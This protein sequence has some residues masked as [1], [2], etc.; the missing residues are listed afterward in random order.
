MASE[1]ADSKKFLPFTRLIFYYHK[2][3]LQS[4]GMSGTVRESRRELHEKSLAKLSTYHE[5]DHV[6]NSSAQVM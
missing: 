4:S 5:P 2:K 3:E 1:E 6:I